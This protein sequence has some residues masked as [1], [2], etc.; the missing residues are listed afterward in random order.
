MTGLVSILQHQSLPYMPLHV[1]DVLL[2]LHR[3]DNIELW[4]PH[5]SLS[6]FW[7][8]SNQVCSHS[9]L[10]CL[11]LTSHHQTGDILHCNEAVQPQ[12]NRPHPVTG[13]SEADYAIPHSLPQ[14]A[15]Q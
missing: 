3:P 2:T 14:E 7:E 1:S 8:I 10:A 5:D 12:D 6:A 9:V 15:Q 4:D 11:S 13:P